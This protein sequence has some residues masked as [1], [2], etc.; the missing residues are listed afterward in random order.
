MRERPR[1][2]RS[3]SPG[4]HPTCEHVGFEGTVDGVFQPSGVSI[5]CW[6]RAASAGG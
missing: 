1:L 6:R 3:K 4:S 5:K 2:T